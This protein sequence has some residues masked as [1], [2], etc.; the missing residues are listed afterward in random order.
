MLHAALKTI[1]E[2]K[3]LSEAEMGRLLGYEER[4]VKGIEDL[5]VSPSLNILRVYSDALDISVSSIIYI[6]ERIR[7]KQKAIDR[8]KAELENPD[9]TE[10]IELTRCT[11][12]NL[13]LVV[14]A[15]MIYPNKTVQDILDYIDDINNRTPLQ[16]V[17]LAIENLKNVEEFYSKLGHI[18]QPHDWGE[19]AELIELEVVR[20]PIT[21]TIAKVDFNTEQMQI[22]NDPEEKEKARLEIICGLVKRDKD[23]CILKSF[24]GETGA[25]LIADKIDQAIVRA[26]IKDKKR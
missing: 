5:T 17:I 25:M 18:I 6:S 20:D 2:Y 10:V 23:L 1:R 11:D 9:R 22:F 4:A 8:F 24:F 7:D 13:S 26:K 21:K 12:L 15:P 16:T 14:G 3:Q 19:V